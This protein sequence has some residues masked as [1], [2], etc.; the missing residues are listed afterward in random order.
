MCYKLNDKFCIYKSYSQILMQKSDCNFFFF[1][2]LIDTNP[3]LNGILFLIQAFCVYF[4]LICT[5]IF[6]PIR[7]TC[8]SL[9]SF[10][11]NLFVH[12]V[13]FGINI[14]IFHCP[15]ISH[16]LSINKL[17]II[18]NCKVK[19]C[20]ASKRVITMLFESCLKGKIRPHFVFVLV[21]CG[22]FHEKAI[23]N[24]SNTRNLS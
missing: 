24:V 1:H 9:L 3:F 16:Y 20:F 19:W 10:S 8:I 11:P 22:Q 18:K 12:F 21:V 23:S 7:E 5:S 6:K 13:L 15:T 4:N 17:W 2:V 14:R